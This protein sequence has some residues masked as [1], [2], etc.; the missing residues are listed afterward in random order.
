MSELSKFFE[1]FRRKIR[2]RARERTTWSATCEKN[3]P[4]RNTLRRAPVMMG[5]KK[6]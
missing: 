2:D 6:V 1:I 3:R 5:Y 4:K